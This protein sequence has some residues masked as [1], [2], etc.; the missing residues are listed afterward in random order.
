[1]QQRSVRP[2]RHLASSP[3]A[4]PAEPLPAEIF[5]ENE[6]VSHDRYGLGRVVV[7]EGVSAVVVDF[8]DTRVR[9]PSPFRQ[10]TKL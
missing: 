6:R 2:R 8:G 7:V 4:P 9:I 1:M 5:T 10:L 3:F